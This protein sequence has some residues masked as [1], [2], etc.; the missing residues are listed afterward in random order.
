VRLSRS[1]P[2]VSG[3][4]YSNKREHD[5]ASQDYDQAIKLDPSLALAFNNRGDTYG[6]CNLTGGNPEAA[7]RVV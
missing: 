1:R 4:A 3:R 5:R 2:I 6:D 7:Y